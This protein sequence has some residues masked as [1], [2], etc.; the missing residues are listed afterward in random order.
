MHAAVLRSINLSPVSVKNPKPI[1]SSGRAFGTVN[2]FFFIWPTDFWTSGKTRCSH[3]SHRSVQ[4]RNTVGL[5]DWRLKV[6]TGCGHPKPWR[7]G[8]NMEMTRKLLP[9]LVFTY[10]SMCL[11]C[12]RHSITQ[13]DQVRPS[14]AESGTGESLN[15]FTWP[16]CPK[17]WRDAVVPKG[18]QKS[19]IHFRR[20]VK[21]DRG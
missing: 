3:L 16:R 14:F 2:I 4:C 7:V 18:L 15:P 6:C 17:Q 19:R 9:T 11:I 21:W 20:R 5:N 13:I 10:K 1:S 8:E 12:F